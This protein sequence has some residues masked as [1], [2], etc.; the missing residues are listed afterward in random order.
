MVIFHGYVNVYQSDPAPVEIP[1]IP[2]GSR[3]RLGRVRQ[4]TA[5]RKTSWSDL[6]NTLSGDLPIDLS[7]WPAQ[8]S[9]NLSIHQP[10]NQSTNQ[11]IYLNVYVDLCIM[12]MLFIWF[13]LASMCIHVHTGV[14]SSNLNSRSNFSD[15]WS[16]EG[17]RGPS[18]EPETSHPSHSLRHDSQKFD[19]RKLQNLNSSQQYRY[20]CNR[21][22]GVQ[23]CVCEM[24]N[25][26]I[27]MYILYSY[28]I[29]SIN[30]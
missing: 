12:H 16:C 26:D 15:R 6:R 20:Y 5:C 10:I 27:H 22:S 21:L 23:H 19:A 24:G 7:I 28:Y 25:H 8:L 2:F 29:K 11:S 18:L 30:T 1:P 14:Q 4:G 9:T 17:I 13:Y 3:A